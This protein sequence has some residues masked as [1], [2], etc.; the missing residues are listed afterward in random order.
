MIRAF[1]EK[2]SYANTIK[3]LSVDILLTASLNLSLEENPDDGNIVLTF[4]YSSFLKSMDTEGQ[5]SVI[6]RSTVLPTIRRHRLEY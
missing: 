3:I 4:L 2:I 5:L 1:T 6:S